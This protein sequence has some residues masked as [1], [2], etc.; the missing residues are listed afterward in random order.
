MHSPY[1][2]LTTSTR[3]RYQSTQ[4]KNRCIPIFGVGQEHGSKADAVSFKDFSPT[5]LLTLD[6]FVT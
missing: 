2:P 6:T 4:P 3:V 1:N 5:T